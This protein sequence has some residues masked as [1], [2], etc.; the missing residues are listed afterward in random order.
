LEG[1]TGKVWKS[2]KGVWPSGSESC[3]QTK[4][5]FGRTFQHST[6]VFGELVKGEL[7][8]GRRISRQQ[9][10]EKRGEE[11]GRRGHPSDVPKPS[12][13]AEVTEMSQGERGC[14]P[15]ILRAKQK[16]DDRERVI[17]KLNRKKGGRWEKRKKKGS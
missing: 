11:S 10:E 6:E 2:L 14:V 16:A 5:E 4:G 3:V 9:R 13:S 8:K 17:I 7:L 1:W 12:G 15:G